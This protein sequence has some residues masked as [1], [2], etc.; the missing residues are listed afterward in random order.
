MNHQLINVATHYDATLRELRAQAV[1]LR[2]LDHNAY[3]QAQADALDGV[4][5]H[6]D[7]LGKAL[8]GVPT[9]QDINDSLRAGA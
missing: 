5:R 4:I 9:W 6:L 2:A 1:A 7:L 8:D 3:A